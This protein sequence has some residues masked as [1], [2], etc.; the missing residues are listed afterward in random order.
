VP[1]QFFRVRQII[2][3]FAIESI[4]EITDIGMFEKSCYKCND[5]QQYTNGYYQCGQLHKWINPEKPECNNIQG[6][7]VNE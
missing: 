1:S 4:Q 6:V 7:K 3:D 5:L 2:N